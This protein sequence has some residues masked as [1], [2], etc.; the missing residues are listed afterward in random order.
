MLKRSFDI[1]ASALGLILLSPLFLLIALWIKVDSKGP[2]FYKQKRVGKG[3]KDFF[4]YKFRSM[5]PNSDKGSLITIGG[6]DPRVTRSG[7][8]IRIL[9]LDEIPQL[10]NVI[11]GDMSLVGPRPEVR[12][13][14]ELYTPEQKRVLSVRPGITDLASIKYRNENQLLEKAEDP[15]DYYVHI[16]M[17]DKLRYN[18]EYIEHQ[19]FLFD[20]KLIFLT[21]IAILKR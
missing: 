15:E 20:L 5:R 18:L 12:R 10:I 21:F 8:Y 7:Y 6:R 9:K 1:V 2:I 13:Y 4:L 11:I 16:V 19:S 17:P 3:G 14:V